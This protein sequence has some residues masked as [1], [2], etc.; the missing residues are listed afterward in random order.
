MSNLK[1]VGKYNELL[2]TNKVLSVINWINRRIFN[3]TL[4]QILVLQ[5]P[6]R[7]K[8]INIPIKSQYLVK[9]FQDSTM[10]LQLIQK[11]APRA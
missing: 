5:L 6:K 10:N 4:S 9:E 11:W 1:Y 8:G 2:T 7:A 3:D